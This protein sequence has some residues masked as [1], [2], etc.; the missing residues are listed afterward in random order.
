MNISKLLST[1]LVVIWMTTI[2][3]FSHQQG[4]G[5]SSTSKKV[6]MAIVNILDIRDQ[7]QEEQKQEIVQVIEPIIR[8]LAHF[9]L[10]MI[11]G[12]LLVNCAYIY[13]RENKRAVLFSSI[14]GVL[15]A[16]SD[17]L[18]QLFI[19]GRSGKATDVLIDGLGVFIGIVVYLLIKRMIEYI[20][21]RVR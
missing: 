9:T 7:M 16:I 12:I 15:Y 5:S 11:G 10:Y 19:N 13:L 18:H 2:F 14:V 17:E 21:E 4:T 20:V 3:Y 1:I 6:S 8:K